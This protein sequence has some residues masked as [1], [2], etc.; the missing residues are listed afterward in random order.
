MLGYP[1]WWEKQRLAVSYV[2]GN[3]QLN[4]TFLPKNTSHAVGKELQ[5]GEYVK[6]SVYAYR[7]HIN[8]GCIFFFLKLP[9]QY[10][11]PS[12]ARRNFFKFLI[13]FVCSIS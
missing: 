2:Y 13:S 5:H 4:I 11:V 12:S 6:F 7:F 9:L 1:A 3:G 8:L 10:L